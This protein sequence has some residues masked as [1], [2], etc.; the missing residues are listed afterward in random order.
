MFFGL[1]LRPFVGRIRDKFRVLLEQE[2]VRHPGDVI[3]D[4]TVPGF[5]LRLDRVIA[6]HGPGMLHVMMEQLR[7]SRNGTLAL[8]YDCRVIVKPPGQK[9]FQ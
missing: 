9:L 3:A 4:N 8:L 5:V 2:M 1:F 7:Q 6:G